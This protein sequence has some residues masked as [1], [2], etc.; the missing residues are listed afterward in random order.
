MKCTISSLGV[1][2]LV[3]FGLLCCLPGAKTASPVSIAHSAADDDGDSKA[4]GAAEIARRLASPVSLDDRID[5]SFHEAIQFMEQKYGLTILVD[6]SAFENDLGLP[7]VGSRNV[8][9]AKMRD[10]RLSTVL[11]KL[12]AQVNGAYLVKADH[13]SIV[14]QPRLEAIV[15]GPAEMADTLSGVPRTQMPLVCT[16]F[17]NKP[18]DAV[19]KELVDATGVSVVLDSRRAGDQAK[20]EVT[21][22]L[23][24]APLDTAVRILANQ[25]EL[26]AVRLDNVLYVTTADNAATLK[27]AAR[28]VGMGIRNLGPPQG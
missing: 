25:A 5:T 14:P 16:V 10:V 23:L 4:S 18:L 22:T 15:W 2:G 24:N 26:E 8:S 17:E 27:P 11:Q 13:V 6:Q 21:A 1:L 12:S 20:A 9:L 19:L 3:M 28:P 7:D